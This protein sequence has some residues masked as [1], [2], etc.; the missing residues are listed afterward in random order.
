MEVLLGGHRQG[1]KEGKGQGI[2][3][4]DHGTQSSQLLSRLI[5]LP[6]HM[7]YPGGW[8]SPLLLGR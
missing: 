2:G 4:Q 8:F 5:S 7:G 3:E 1:W 6:G